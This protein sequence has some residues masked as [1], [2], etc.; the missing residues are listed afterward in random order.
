MFLNN[1]YVIRLWT[2]AN[3]TYMPLCYTTTCPL[4]LFLDAVSLPSTTK[5]REYLN[6]ALHTA[7]LASH[8]A[9]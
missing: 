3:H 4:R 1:L 7:N 6:K 2:C 8:M 5:I 9:C